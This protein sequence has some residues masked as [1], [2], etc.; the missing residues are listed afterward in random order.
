MK[1]ELDL[2]RGNLWNP[3]RD[4]RDLQKDFNRLFEAPSWPAS[5]SKA[6]NEPLFAPA[7]DVSETDTQYTLTFDIP[8]MRKEE[9][10]IEIQDRDLVVSGERREEKTEDKKT[11]HVTER[12]YGSFRRAIS[13]PTAALPEKAQA[14]FANGVLQVTVPKS[15]AAKPK[16]IAI[17]DGP[18]E[19]GSG[20]VRIA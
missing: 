3:M 11:S 8:G 10:K 1:Q 9:I 13:L 15:S 2:F 16:T 14:T 19:S 20:S 6:A 7:C 4:F 5:F 12:Y 18:R 17:T